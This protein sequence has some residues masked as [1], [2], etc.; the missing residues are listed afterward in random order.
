M[1]N[2]LGCL[3]IVFLLLT[4]CSSATKTGNFRFEPLSDSL[5]R[6]GGTYDETRALWVKYYEECMYQQV[7]P[8]TFY[9]GIQDRIYIGSIN[10][11]QE[12]A[13]NKGFHLLD[14]S[15]SKSVF[16]LVGII[17]SANCNA[18]TLT[19]N[20][21]IQRSFYHEVIRVL[22]TSETFSPIADVLD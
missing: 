5:Y 18:S 21:T 3:L 4:G 1:K 15:G 8:G 16:N 9:L 13:V 11:Q 22:S 14:T 10:N 6:P 20:P 2:N 7:F 17:N 12:V 19:L